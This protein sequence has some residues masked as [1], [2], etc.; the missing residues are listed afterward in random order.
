MSEA[1]QFISKAMHYLADNGRGCGTWVQYGPDNDGFRI[2]YAAEQYVE[3]EAEN[4]RLR[5]ENDKLRDADTQYGAS[6]FTGTSEEVISQA[7]DREQ[8]ELWVASYPD[9]ARELM[10]RRVGP[11]TPVV[12]NEES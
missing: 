1:Q 3:L 7:F 12:M 9:E 6:W 8:A 11:W 5:T 10:Q 4:E 2:G